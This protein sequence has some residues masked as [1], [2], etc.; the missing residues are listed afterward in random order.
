MCTLLKKILIDRN[1]I[2]M[3]DDVESHAASLNMIDDCTYED[4]ISSITTNDYLPSYDTM[5]LVRTKNRGCMAAYY[6]SSYNND[7]AE[8]IWKQG[9]D[10]TCY[11]GEDNSFYFECFHFKREMYQYSPQYDQKVEFIKKLN[12]IDD[13][14][15]MQIETYLKKVRKNRKA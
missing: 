11:V 4:V 5:W 12:N 9:F 1:S 15:Y 8:V 3:G 14:F 10:K 2:C 7:N 6:K 13:E